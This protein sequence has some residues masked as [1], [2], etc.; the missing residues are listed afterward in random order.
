MMKMI[1]YQMLRNYSFRKL[2]SVKVFGQ[3][4]VNFGTASV[5]SRKQVL[6]FFNTMRQNRDTIT[7]HR[8]GQFFEPR[9]CFCSRCFSVIILTCMLI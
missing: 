6:K 9:G 2:F 5:R 8:I 4:F 7:F 1:K 3:E